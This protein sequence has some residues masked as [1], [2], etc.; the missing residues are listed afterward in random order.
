MEGR[1]T[2]LATKLRELGVDGRAR[3]TETNT[4]WPISDAGHRDQHPVAHSRSHDESSGRAPG[5]LSFTLL[6]P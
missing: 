1:R 3:A 2:E 4:W 6:N 5:S